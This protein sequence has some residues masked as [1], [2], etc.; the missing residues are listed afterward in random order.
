MILT[1]KQNKDNYRICVDC[2]KKLPL[3]KEYFRPHGKNKNG[4]RHY[5]KECSKKRTQEK[6]QATCIV[7]GC[8]NKVKVLKTGLCGKHQKRL[9][10]YNDINFVTPKEVMAKHS[11]DAK[12][13][14]MK[15]KKTTYKKFHNRHEHRVVAEKMLGRPLKK[16]EVVHHKDENKHNN[17]PSNLIVFEN[18]AEHAR[19]HKNIEYKQ[20]GLFL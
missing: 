1:N 9:Y 6:R 4:Y 5:C 13:K 12:L 7:E 2:G 19:H 8:K 15:A 17:D 16:G 20:K 10:L 14:I 18:Q 11:R 3:T